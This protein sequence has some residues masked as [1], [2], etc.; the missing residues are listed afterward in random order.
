MQNKYIKI[1]LQ[2]HKNTFANIK[3]D[4]GH[5]YNCD[6]DRDVLDTSIDIQYVA[7]CQRQSK[8]VCVTTVKAF[9]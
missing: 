1:R 3:P 9:C 8:I 5:S 2:I 7:I 4:G 6:C